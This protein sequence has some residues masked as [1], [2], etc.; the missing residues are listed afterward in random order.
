V[1]DRLTVDGISHKAYFR[2]RLPAY[3]LCNLNVLQNFGSYLKVYAGVNN[4]FNYKPKTLGSGL[5]AFSVPA[6]AGARVYVQMEV[7]LDALFHK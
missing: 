7:K 5:T 3:V 4:L 1:Q 6:T 2:C